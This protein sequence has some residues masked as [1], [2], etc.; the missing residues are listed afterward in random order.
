MNELLIAAPAV[1]GGYAFLVG[2]VALVASIHSD[3]KR[4]R[5]AA[6]ILDR[7]LRTKERDRH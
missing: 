7:L 4:R 5:D 3:E 6:R 1:A 2:I